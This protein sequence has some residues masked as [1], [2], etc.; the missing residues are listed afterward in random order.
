MTIANELGQNTQAI[1][2]LRNLILDPGEV[3]N[4]TNANIP[5]YHG[6]AIG[7]LITFTWQSAAGPSFTTT[8]PVNAGNVGAPI[9]VRIAYDPYIIGNVDISVSVSYEVKRKDGPDAKSQPLSFLIQWQRGKED[10]QGIAPTELRVGQNLTT[11]LGT[12][13]RLLSQGGGD[14]VCKI[15]NGLLRLTSSSRVRLTIPFPAK[16]LKAYT[17]SSVDRLGVAKIS[18]YNASSHLETLQVAR[19]QVAVTTYTAP[20]G[21]MIHYI[22]VDGVQ[23]GQGYVLIN[24]LAW[25]L[26]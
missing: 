24:E 16:T 19:E 18:Y 2:G 4:G 11:P 23:A 3:P 10:F 13:V 5:Q 14:K 8:I 1:V 9:P 21:E 7:D 6:K 25:E 17:I 26:K 20:E 22:E 12:V 15:E